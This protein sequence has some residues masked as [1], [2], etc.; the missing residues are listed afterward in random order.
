MKKSASW[1]M[2]ELK[3]IEELYD[4][5]RCTPELRDALREEVFRKLEQQMKPEAVTEEKTC[6]TKTQKTGKLQKRSRNI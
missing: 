1:A 4:H 6:N 2:R 3:A 5:A